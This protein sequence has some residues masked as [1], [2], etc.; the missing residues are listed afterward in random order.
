M[1]CCEG[2]GDCDDDDD[3]AKGLICGDDNCSARFYDGADCCI[4]GNL[5]NH[6]E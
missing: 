5:I 4:K 3:C 1:P 2:Q 6:F